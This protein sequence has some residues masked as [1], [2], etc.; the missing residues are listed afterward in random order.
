MGQVRDRRDWAAS[1]LVAMGPLWLG[2]LAT[3]AAADRIVLRGGGQIKGK[4]ITDPKQP[5]RVTVL[6]ERGKTPLSF[7]KAQ[8]V[9]VVAEPSI[10]DDYVARRDRTSQTADAQFELGTW[11]EQHKLADLAWIHFEA[12]LRHDRSFAPAHQKLGHVFYRNQWLSG[13]ELREAQGLVRYKGKWITRDE[14]A[15]REK[16]AAAAAD[17]VAWSRRIKLLRESVL[18]SSEDRQREAESQLMEIRDPIAI[19][20]LI[21]VMG[22]DDIR[23][24]ILLSHILGAIPGSE[25]TEA[26]VKRLFGESESD[27][28][29]A[30]VD[31]LARRKEAEVTRLLVRGLRSTEPTVIN[32]A[33]WGLATLKVVSAVPTL[34]GSL[35]TTRYQVV[36]S[37]GGAGGMS[38]G[39]SIT[40]SFGSGPVASPYGG[41]PI[42]Y[43]GSS[44]G[45]LTGA[46]VG[47]DSVG[48]GVSAAPAY[49]VVNAGPGIPGV[50]NGGSLTPPRVPVPKMLSVPVRNTEVLSA[51]VK[52]TGNDFGYD[53]A[54]WKQWV[55]TSYESSPTPA[56]RVPQP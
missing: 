35:I 22:D 14:L 13:N 23:N 3:S 16:D 20:P 34:V 31:E 24:R 29:Y 27:V 53:V 28:R 43:N 6:T 21:R 11:C 39:S 30:I 52:L 10:L 5:D 54:A 42:A 46:A 36:M 18:Y 19:A 44:V 41:T 47:P 8:I 25:A 37:G 49:P 2:L 17:Q 50:P 15:Q 51:L 40:A 32:R 56:K 45:Y 48:Y 26:L 12:A 38:E 4:V 1:W 33:A 55:Q 7:Q 9:S